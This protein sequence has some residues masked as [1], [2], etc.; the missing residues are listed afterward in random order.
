MRHVLFVD[1]EP[2]VLDGLRK[3]LRSHRHEWTVETANSGAEGLARLELGG[4]DAVLSDLS[5][6]AM[7]GEVF[8]GMVRE[9]WPE[10][11]RVVLS[12]HVEA[13][14][15]R[16]LVQIVHQFLP[17]PFEVQQLFALVEEA[18][19]SRDLLESPALRRLVGK[20]GDLPALPQTFSAL[21]AEMREP[22]P[23]F[24]R[25][26]RIVGADPSIAANVLRLVNSAWF[27]LSRKVPSIEEAVRLIGLKPIE[28]LVLSAEVYGSAAA[29]AL[30]AQ[31][32]FV[33]L[34]RA[35]TVRRL[36]EKA[37]LTQFSAAA[38]TAAVLSDVGLVVL[39]TRDPDTFARVTEEKTRAACAWDLAERRVL[40][41]HHG[42]LGGALLGFWSLP[43][44]VRQ[45]VTRHH[46]P[47]TEVPAVS[48]ASALG[49]VVVLE[50]L[51]PGGAP[52]ARLDAE[53]EVLSKAYPGLD[54][55]PFLKSKQHE[56][57]A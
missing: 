44:E 42:V 18:L 37:G 2:A 8:L 28:L 55:A 52:D 24:Q 34:E 4:I 23:S 35:R 40:G 21:L 25:I 14:V 5:M 33:A 1:D 13:A 51:E 39:A 17:K 16:R 19:V 31:L 9:R 29:G 22:N 32:Q 10:V 45:A 15:A 41:T 56:E 7:N 11:V 6:P 57:A 20:L 54:L 12:G 43:T 49:L 50:E 3:A 53:L 48:P 27:G 26:A 30:G 38:Q 36:L 46:G 47:W